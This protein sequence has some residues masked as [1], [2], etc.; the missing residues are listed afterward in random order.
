MKNALVYSKYNKARTSV[1]KVSP[2]ID[3][4]RGKGVAE[5]AN[6]LQFNKTKASDIV[7]KVLNSAV[8]NAKNNLS[9]NEKDLYVSEIFVNGGPTIKRGR[10]VARGRFSPILKRTAHIVVG[11]SERANKRS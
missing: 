8:A 11:L 4:V 6:I 10:I 7:L 5:A 1:K 2:V 9:L 3:L